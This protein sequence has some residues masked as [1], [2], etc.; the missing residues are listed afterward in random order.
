MKKVRAEAPGLDAGA[1]AAEEAAVW[2]GGREGTGEGRGQT[3]CPPAHLLGRP[4]VHT[5]AAHKG[6]VHA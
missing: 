2:K 3:P 5:Y 4:G 1:E 6:N